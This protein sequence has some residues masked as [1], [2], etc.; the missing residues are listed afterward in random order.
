MVCMVL[1]FL[2][3]SRSRAHL[4]DFFLWKVLDPA[5]HAALDGASTPTASPPSAQGIQG[6]LQNSDS[7]TLVSH[8][9]GLPLNV[10]DERPK[11]ANTLGSQSGIYVQSV[12]SNQI[13]EVGTPQKVCNYFQ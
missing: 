12:S 10:L 13:P 6:K 5:L 7:A 1:K 9:S 3:T 2:R 8:Y 4:P 11:S